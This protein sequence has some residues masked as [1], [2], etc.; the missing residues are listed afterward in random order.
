MGVDNC[1][2]NYTLPQAYNLGKLEA[3]GG[4]LVF[5]HDDVEFLNKDWLKLV[6]HELEDD[7]VGAIGSAGGTKFFNAPST[8]WF[9]L[10][11]NQ[12]LR[13]MK[14]GPS[15][16]PETFRDSVI[17]QDV[18]CLDG[19][20]LIC[21]ADDLTSFQWSDKIGHWHGYDLDLSLHM[22]FKQEKRN[23][24]SPKIFVRHGSKG[25][26]NEDWALA[27]IAV[28]KKYESDL[29]G[30]TNLLHSYLALIQFINWTHDFKNVGVSLKETLKR[31]DL[32]WIRQI[33]IGCYSQS[34]AI[35]KVSFFTLKVCQIILQK[36]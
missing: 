7:S 13:N 34:P 4:I 21:R 5:V 24:I 25:T 22:K 36:M 9:A 15:K 11:N 30:C 10:G 31:T 2:S 17:S 32:R 23:I 16:N 3:R 14:E 6:R 20:I 1:Q 8:W 29:S 19:F 33:V 18:F 27:M 26:V 28:W 12:P 35:K